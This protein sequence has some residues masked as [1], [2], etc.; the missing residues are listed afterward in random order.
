MTLHDDN[1]RRQNDCLKSEASLRYTVN[2]KPTTAAEG[3]PV[4]K[5]NKQIKTRTEKKGRERK[6][7]EGR[8]KNRGRG[9][10]RKRRKKEGGTEGP[11]ERGR[12]GEKTAAHLLLSFLVS[13]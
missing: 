11:R 6:E 8:E 13:S 2:S 1:G 5:T 12:E 10:E 3:N 7:E 9:R 4:Q